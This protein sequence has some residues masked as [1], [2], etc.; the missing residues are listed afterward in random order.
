MQDTAHLDRLDDD[1]HLGDGDAGLDLLN[2][3]F[4]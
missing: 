3:G 1:R 4:D 2:L